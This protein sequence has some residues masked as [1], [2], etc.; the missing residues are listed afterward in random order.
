MYMPQRTRPVRVA[1]T[2]GHTFIFHP[3]EPVMVPASCVSIAM[4]H[5]AV[6]VDNADLAQITAD[7]AAPP[8][9]PSVEERQK[10]LTEMFEK[11]FADQSGYRDAFTAAGR[12]N[13]Y[14]LER[15]LNVD[16]S[17]S[18]VHSLWTEFLAEKAAM[19]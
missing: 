18:E 8:R 5:G 10:L 4:Q 15:Q 6:P 16:L 1:T 17:A 9:A 11:L 12:P 2:L 3:N 19:K 14:W 7:E 13:T